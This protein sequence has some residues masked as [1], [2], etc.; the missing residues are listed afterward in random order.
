MKAESMAKM[1]EG[2]AT[3]RIM[4]ARGELKGLPYEELAV[5]D[6][7]AHV[8]EVVNNLFDE[9]ASEHVKS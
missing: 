7:R 6:C 4:Q 3:F 2:E 9:I 5:D 1:I 8:L